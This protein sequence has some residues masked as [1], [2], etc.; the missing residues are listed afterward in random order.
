MTFAVKIEMAFRLLVSLLPLLAGGGCTTHKLWSTSGFD[1]F[2]TPAENLNLRLFAGAPDGDLLVVYNEYSE[3]H[4]KTR[5]RAYLLRKNQIRIE[6]QRPPLFAKTKSFAGLNPVPVFVT[7]N[8]IASASTPFYAVL[9]TNSQSFTLC[10][11]G[12]V[13]GPYPLP[14]YND[15]KG[16]V[17]RIALTPLTATADL[18]IVGGVLGY[19]YA[20]ALW[21][22]GASFK[23][24]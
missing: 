10:S 2:N 6:Q 13:T 14:V 1:N 20:E 4:D 19:C 11:D 8:A 5:T 24:P 21:P 17:E 23:F 9:S 22:N 15:G 12:H 7:T 16:Q 3:R 18:T